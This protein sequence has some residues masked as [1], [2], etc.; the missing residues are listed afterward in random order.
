MIQ[1][2]EVQLADIIRFFQHGN[3]SPRTYHFPFMEPAAQC[4]GTD[5]TTGLCM[6]LRLVEQLM[7]IIDRHNVPHSC[8]EIELTE[9]TTDVAFSDLKRVVTGLQSAGIFA[10]VDDFGIGYSSLNL[11]RELPWNVL[12]VDR[13]ILPMEDDEPDSVN[14]IMFRYV[15][16]MVNELGIECIV[17]GVETEKQLEILRMNNCH[18]AQGFL[19]DKPLPVAQFEERMSLGYYEI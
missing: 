8:I 7:K 2:V 14:S 13:S 19:F 1:H 5:H 16:A 4:L 9:T 15:I 3:E 17:E 11:I 18:Y 12:K 10:S 6:H